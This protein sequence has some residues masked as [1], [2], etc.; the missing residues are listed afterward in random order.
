M[1]A[2]WHVGLSSQVTSNRTRE[3]GLK[4]WQGVFGLNIRENFFTKNVVL[5]WQRLPRALVKSSFLEGF[6]KPC[7][8]GTWGHG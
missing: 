1:D 3:D 8:C 4:L 7:G 5:P 6:L 2:V